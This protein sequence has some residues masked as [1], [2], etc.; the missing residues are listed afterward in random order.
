MRSWALLQSALAALTVISAILP[1]AT[2]S[3]DEL[4]SAHRPQSGLSAE[5]ASDD[6][7]SSSSGAP[8]PAGC[9][10][11]AVQLRGEIRAGSPKVAAAEQ[12]PGTFMNPILRGSYADPSIIRV[13]GDYYMVSSS[14]E[15]FPGI[16]IH[17]SKDLVN[18]ELVGYALHRPEQVQG[19]VN[20]MDV[21]QDG[22]IQAATIRYNN[23]KFY[24][25]T[26]SVYQP[27]GSENGKCINFIVEADDVRG[28]W[29]MPHVLADADGIDSSLFFDDN[30]SVWYVGAH[31]PEHPEY[32]GQGEIYLREVDLGSWTLKGET[33]ILFHGACGGLW[34]EGP[35]IY[36]HDGRYYL[37]V[38]EGG[39]GFHHAV[40]AAVSD[41][42]RGPYYSNPRNPILTARHLSYDNW[43]TRVGHADLVELPDGR[44]YAV[45]LGVRGDVNRSSNMGRESFLVPMTWERE[46]DEYNP[47]YLWPVVAPTTAGVERV[48]PLPF[49]DLAFRYKA[50]FRDEFQEADL[51][52]EWNFR[53]LPTQGTFSLTALSGF[54]R[55]FAKPDVMSDSERSRCSL[56]G[57]RQEESDFTYRARMLFEP[58]S[59]GVE[60]GV[61]LWQKDDIYLQYTVSR[62]TGSWVLSLLFTDRK[63]PLQTLASA[64]LAGYKGEIIFEVNC[65]RAGYSFGYSLGESEESIGLLEE[66]PSDMLVYMGY[67]GAYLGIYSSSGGQQ[68]QLGD[69]ADF[70]W[71]ERISSPRL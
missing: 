48:N 43:V 55:L 17:H 16:P 22:G 25:V 1:E 66:A 56:L 51:E 11:S 42:I 38:A 53:R 23:G 37:M 20:L 13:G 21:Q 9:A 32:P 58:N 67:T 36:K 18:W 19:E 59:S 41:D 71:V 49:A 50:G 2:A 52:L 14:F 7:C 26:T 54:L 3:S 63:T 5:L 30:G 33:S 12:R 47:Q 10:L 45:A 4:L 46:P 29:S 6:E 35:H 57:V 61:M 44:W 39:T 24:I 31:S 65:S 70:D 62:S 40:M 69:Y 64:N 8:P 68:P 15:Y 28:P 27:P 34:V 60:A